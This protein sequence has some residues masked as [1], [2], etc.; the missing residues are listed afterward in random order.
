MS[1]SP[2]KSQPEQDDRDIIVALEHAPLVRSVLDLL[3]VRLESPPDENRA[4][5]LARITL[6]GKLEARTLQ[7]NL[8]A[9]LAKENCAAAAAEVSADDGPARLV[10]GH[11]YNYF[12][13]RYA[14][15]N[16][17]MGRNRLM[18][19]VT[20]GGGTVSYGGGPAPQAVKHGEG[21]PDRTGS[22]NGRVTV[23]VLDT[24][25][26]AHPWLA[27]SYVAASPADF[28]PK[29]GRP[30]LPY[31]A[32][33]ATFVSGLIVDRAPNVTLRVRGVLDPDGTATSWDVATAIVELGQ[34]G[35]DI[36]NLSLVCYTKDAQPPL[37]LATAVSKVD[38][39]VLVVACAGNHGD[40][41]LE[42]DDADTRKPAWPAALDNVV[43]VGSAKRT[44]GDLG[45]TVSDFTPK[46]AVWIDV[47]T[48]G[49]ELTSTYFN[50]L[51]V[52]GKES[53]PPVDFDGWAKW[54][55]TSFSAA[56]VS[57]AVAARADVDRIP[58]REAYHR[59]AGPV[60]AK[61]VDSY[62]DHVPPFLDV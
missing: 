38:P 16:P 25:L 30:R 17:T 62:K 26:V 58:A 15:W 4:L 24:D 51:G 19:N 32:G 39:G 36:L 20:G 22:P 45:Y 60:R 50:G 57:G 53:D 5:G 33:H 54:G 42:L 56:R 55:G 3:D 44:D 23:G 29:E 59:L 31:A 2:E 52:S 40:P 47:V 8:D 11:L 27:G 7:M 35:I 41:Q 49:E 34:S 61:S 18:G 13:A 14:M 12:R 28:Q 1:A 21:L 9:L 6:A 37:V 46:D 43:A 48:H 10:L